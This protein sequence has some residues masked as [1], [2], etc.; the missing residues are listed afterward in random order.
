MKT[1]QQVSTVV[2]PQS[3][4]R[5]L[6][7]R[8]FGVNPQAVNWN[9]GP[10]AV[11]WNSEPVLTAEER[12]FRHGEDRAI[13]GLSLERCT[14]EAQRAGW[15]AM[16]DRMDSWARCARE[17]YTPEIDVW[18]GELLQRQGEADRRRAW[19]L[20]LEAE[21]DAILEEMESPFYSGHE[22]EMAVA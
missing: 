21:A 22:H 9:S 6:S 15:R 19:A 12:A 3:D 18:A 5:T 7:Q 16:T 10:Q 13:L 20:A 2:N 8:L 4:T 1:V 17:F 14:N 11:N